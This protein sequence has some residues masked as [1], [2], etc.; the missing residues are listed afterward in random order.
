MLFFFT[1]TIQMLNG[2]TVFN[3]ANKYKNKHI[4]IYIS[5]ATNQHMISE[6]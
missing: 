2:T 6:G 1:V 3:I 5:W 4:Y